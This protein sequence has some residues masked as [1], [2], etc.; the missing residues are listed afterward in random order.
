MQ[1]TPNAKG[2]MNIAAMHMAAW[3]G[4][5]TAIPHLAE[6]GTNIKIRDSHGFISL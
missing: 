5:H 1:G 4:I 2:V 3:N 6:S